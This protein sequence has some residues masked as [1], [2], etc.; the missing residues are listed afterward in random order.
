DIVLCVDGIGRK[1][2][3]YL[4]EGKS[5]GAIYWHPDTGAHTIYGAIYELWR[6]M[7][8]EQFTDYPVTDT[9]V[10]A[11]GT[12]YFNRFRNVVGDSFNSDVDD[13]IYWHPTTGVHLIYGAIYKKW[14]LLGCE[15]SS[16][17]YPTSSENAG[18]PGSRRSKFQYGIIAWS[19]GIGTWIVEPDQN[20]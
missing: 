12:G 4:T 15:R 9:T 18:P 20:W 1:V 10:C 3:F 6:E 17:G 11:D 14:V 13:A 8:F 2:L 7:D 19:A 5:E 16:L